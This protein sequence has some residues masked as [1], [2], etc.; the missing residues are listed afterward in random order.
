MNDFSLVTSPTR[1]GVIL[2]GGHKIEKMKRYTGRYEYIKDSTSDAM[3]LMELSKAPKS[4]WGPKDCNS[5]PKLKWT[6]L[7][8]KLAHPTSEHIAFP[9][10]NDVFNN[11]IRD[12]VYHERNSEEENPKLKSRYSIEPFNIMPIICLGIFICF[13]FFPIHSIIC[14]ILLSSALLK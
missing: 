8:E 10:N 9:I 4:L 11:L 1:K 6:I 3:V 7:K 12:G 5:I 2:I 13:I 14:G